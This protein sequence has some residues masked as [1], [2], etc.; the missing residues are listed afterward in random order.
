VLAVL[1]VLVLTTI[2]FVIG[3][4]GDDDPPPS[5]NPDDTP[6]TSSSAGG[7]Q[8]EA[9]QEGMESFIE[10]YLSLVTRDPEAAFEMLT[11]EFQ[12]DSGGIEGYRG[13]WDTVSNTKLISV[14]AH[15]ETMVV[16]YRYSYVVRGEGPETDDVS[17]R[18]EHTEDGRYLI[19]GE[20]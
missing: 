16:D 11:P 8:T 15:P 3:L 7:P 2:A 13:W 20:A 4:A 17:L 6:T 9:T 14:E 19:A 12:E 1:A 10:D 18:L 5:S